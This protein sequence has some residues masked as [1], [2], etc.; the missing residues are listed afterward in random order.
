MNEFAQKSPKGSPSSQCAADPGL[1][2]G[3]LEKLEGAAR[4]GIEAWSRGFTRTAN[5][6]AAVR[7]QN[8]DFAERI[9]QLNL[10]TAHAL[11]GSSARKAPVSGPLVWGASVMQLCLGYLGKSAALIQHAFDLVGEGRKFPLSD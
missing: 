5:F 2:I 9:F 4:G 3:S 7:N 10:K 8:A 11:A 1:A 6:A